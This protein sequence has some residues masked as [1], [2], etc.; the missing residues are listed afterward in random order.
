MLFPSRLTNSDRPTSRPSLSRGP[1]TCCSY[2][3]MLRMPSVTGCFIKLVIVII[4]H[5]L[6][7][8]DV[9]WKCTGRCI[10][11]AIDSFHCAE[12][13]WAYYKFGSVVA[14]QFSHESTLFQ[15]VCFLCCVIVNRVWYNI[16]KRW[17]YLCGRDYRCGNTCC[18]CV[19]YRYCCHC[20]IS[21]DLFCTC[22]KQVIKCVVKDPNIELS[23]HHHTY[24][25][26][27]SWQ[28]KFAVCA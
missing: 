1:L 23:T 9:Y 10:N 24:V 5:L 28:F 14:F 8:R 25:I 12:R 6:L 19:W 27:R 15:S 4:S 21:G 16:N 17:Y 22:C 7:Y 13:H 3:W 18:V 20:V 26:V 2:H 11:I